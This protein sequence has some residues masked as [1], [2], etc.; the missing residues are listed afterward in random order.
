MGDTFVQDGQIWKVCDSCQRDRPIGE[1]VVE[2]GETLSDVC[3]HCE[4]GH[5]GTQ[6]LDLESRPFGERLKAG[7]AAMSDDR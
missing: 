6:G 5:A 4:G 2:E 7:F 3:C 1:F